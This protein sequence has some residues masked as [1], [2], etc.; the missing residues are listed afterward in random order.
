MNYSFMTYFQFVDPTRK[1][2]E[3]GSVPTENLPTK[4]HEVEKKKRR[5]L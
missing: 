4:S 1:T 5:T 2:L 3:T